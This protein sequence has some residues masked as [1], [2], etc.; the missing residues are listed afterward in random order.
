MAEL[1]KTSV[2]RV[3][4]VHFLFQLRDGAIKYREYIY[5]SDSRRFN[6]VRKMA[7]PHD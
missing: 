7:I 2:E 6:H 5:Y 3:A 4:F 1:M